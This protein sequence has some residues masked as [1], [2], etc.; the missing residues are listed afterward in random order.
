M[1]RVLL[2][3][4]DPTRLY[5]VHRHKC[6]SDSVSSLKKKI[7]IYVYTHT[8]S[9]LTVCDRVM[10]G[11]LRAAILHEWLKI[12]EKKSRAR[13]LQVTPPTKL[14]RLLQAALLTGV[15]RPRQVTCGII[16]WGTEWS[17]R[18]ITVTPRDV[19]FLQLTRHTP[20]H[21]ATD[22]CHTE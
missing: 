11:V 10:M 17:G 8:E 22:S 15:V 6:T 1:P 3:F 21:V 5:G 13:N 9:R 14:E 18:V 2:Y 16:V 12:R 7:Y 4:Y 19:Q 20:M